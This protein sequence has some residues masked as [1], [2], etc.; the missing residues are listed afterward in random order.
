[1]INDPNKLFKKQTFQEASYKVYAKET[2]YPHS[3]RI[4]IPKQPY[5]KLKEGM[6]SET[7]TSIGKGITDNDNLERSLRR[8]KSKIRDIA[9]C[10]EFELF[11]TLTMKVDRQDINKSKT[12]VINW[13]K[14]QQKRNGKFEYLAVPEFHKDKKSLHYHSLLKGYTG[15]VVQA[16]SPKTGEI[17]NNKYNLKSYTLGFSDVRKIKQTP[18][19]FNRVANYITKYVTKD[20]PLLFGKNRYWASHSLK[21][22]IVIENP[23]EWYKDKKPDWQY[24]SEYGTTMIFNNGKSD[25]K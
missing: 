4:F 8:T 14:N 16:V 11:I 12:K 6:E 25:V 7:K 3:S 17:L 13:F 20:M 19:D 23:P 9:L 22:P 1:M 21:R 5:S 18:D 15:E 2:Q 24:E 10:N